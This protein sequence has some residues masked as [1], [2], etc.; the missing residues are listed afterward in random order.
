MSAISACGQAPKSGGRISPHA[1]VV[2][3]GTD[4][5]YRVIAL[6][7]EWATVVR[8]TRDNVVYPGGLPRKVPMAQWSAWA[9]YLPASALPL[10][11]DDF[12]SLKP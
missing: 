9:L 2:E 4:A 8:C 11:P 12:D 6:G 3:A 5:I 7:E 10:T 1:V